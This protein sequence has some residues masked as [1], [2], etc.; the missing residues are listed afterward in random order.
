MAYT[1]IAG[2]SRMLTHEV[3]IL[4]KP[5]TSMSVDDH[6]KR[7]THTDREVRLNYLVPPPNEGGG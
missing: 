7:H 3:I 4:R 1:H 6:L 5:K 2:I